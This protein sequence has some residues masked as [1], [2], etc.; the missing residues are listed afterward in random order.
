MA[1]EPISTSDQAIGFLMSLVREHARPYQA[2]AHLA[3]HPVRALLA[4]VGDPHVDLP[5]VHIAGSKGK[6]STALYLEAILN[7]AGLS[8][9][10]FTS[11]HLQR[12][13]ERY[14]VDG[15]ESTAAEFSAL[16][17]R[18]QPHVLALQGE[19]EESAPGFFDV[20]TAAA[21]V[22]FAEKRVD[23]AIIETGI[24]GRLD[25]T[26][27]VAPMLGCITSVECEHTD[28]LGTSIAAIAAEKA[29][30]IKQGLPMVIGPLPDDAESVIRERAAGLGAAVSALG[31]EIVLSSRPGPDGGLAIRVID[32]GREY[33][34]VLPAIASDCHA[35]NAALA[36]A[37]AQRV[38]G[39][40]Q[41]RLQRAV[42]RALADTRPPGRMEVVGEHPWVVID[43]AHTPAS[44][45][46]LAEML[47]GLP[48]RRMH[49]IVSLSATRDSAAVLAPLLERAHRVVITSAEA[50][51]SLDSKQV[52]A[53]LVAGGYPASRLRAIPDPRKAVLETHQAL[54]PHD[55]LCIAGSMYMAG[56]ARET[57]LGD[58][59]RPRLL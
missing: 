24:G 41:A 50:T 40:S 54:A 46:A 9:G 51:R 18:L 53:A 5:V 8:T 28:K 10:T 17:A 38:A 22:L 15:R 19:N 39:C 55:L 3:Q 14:R 23:C 6:G 7:A 13:S 35:R 29:G 1:L 56:V 26:N 47:K 30:I 25:A 44:T 49:L 42:A 32:A 34:A 4:R 37:C 20:L 11:P 52:A 57:L 2:R 27:V 59:A 33:Q 12:W 31:Q 43:G 21:F 58:A 16:F 48:A 36:I 45:R